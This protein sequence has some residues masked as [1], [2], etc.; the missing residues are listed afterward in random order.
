MSVVI[1]GVALEPVRLRT[2]ESD[3]VTLP[4]EDL[5]A[6]PE[7]PDSPYPLEE[8]PVEGIDLTEA[9]ESPEPLLSPVTFA[10]DELLPTLEVVTARVEVSDLTVARDSFL[11]GMDLMLLSESPL[12][13]EA[14]GLELTVDLSLVVIV[15]VAAAVFAE[16]EAVP[17]EPRE[18]LYSAALV[19]PGISLVR[20]ALPALVA[21]VARLS[22]AF[23]E[24][25]R[26]VRLWEA[27]PAAREALDDVLPRLSG[28]PALKL[29]LTSVETFLT[30]VFSTRRL[31]KSVAFTT[32]MPRLLL[33]LLLLITMVLLLMTVL[34][35]LL[36]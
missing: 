15:L 24:L 30:M 7:F 26:A 17:A 12:V 2:R 34:L 8:I 20:L 13:P 35:G 28:R 19:E 11:E 1:L 16:R 9:P 3:W 36:P 10:G 27:A 21:A 33:I 29:L 22:E 5:V 32:V 6:E 14:S 18:F 4:L 25:L 31:E 23:N